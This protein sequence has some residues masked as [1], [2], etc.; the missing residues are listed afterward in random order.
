MNQDDPKNWPIERH[1]R[2]WRLFFSIM[3]GALIFVAALLTY[4][5]TL[6]WFRT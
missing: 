4:L 3:G 6:L 5:A 2:V 1:D